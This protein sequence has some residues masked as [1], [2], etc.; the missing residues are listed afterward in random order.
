MKSKILSIVIGILFV[1]IAFGTVA[2]HSSPPTYVLLIHGYSMD[3]SYAANDWLGGVNIYQTLVNQGYI[4]GLVS[5]YGVFSITFS[6]GL[7]FTDPNFYGTQN[8][9]IENVADELGYALTEIFGN[10]GPVNL[11]IVAHSMGGLVTLYMLENFKIPN[12]NLVNVI[13]IASPFNGSPFASIASYLGLDIF[14]GYQAD[15]MDPGSSFL[16]NLQNNMINAINNYPSTTF[17]VYIGTYDPWWGYIFFNDDND[18]VVDYSSATNVY[19][20]YVYTFPDDVHTYFLDNLTC[21][22]ISYFEDPAVVQEILNN[23]SG[24]Y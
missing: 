8:T 17:I 14:V 15:E 19:Y 18:G 22:G 24:S 20:N 16:N 6:N 2:A 5:Y 3:G 11:D 21:S 10:M 12:V 9:P 13:Y 23:L 4:V 7:N 1:I